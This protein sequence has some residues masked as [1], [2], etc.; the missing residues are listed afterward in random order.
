MLTNKEGEDFTITE[1]EVWQVKFIVIFNLKL[2]LY[3]TDQ[4]ETKKEK[5]TK[6]DRERQNDRKTE[7]VKERNPREQLLLSLLLF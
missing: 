4:D 1:L 2:I 5:E 7:T 3:R 6:R